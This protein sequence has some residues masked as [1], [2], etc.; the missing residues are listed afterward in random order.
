VGKNKFYLHLLRNRAEKLAQR[1][2][3]F[4][5][6]KTLTNKLLSYQLHTQDVVQAI[7][8]SNHNAGGWYLNRGA[9]QLVIRGVG[10]VHHQLALTKV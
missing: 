5:V 9:E 8:D 1:L 4:L 10:W 7:E 2:A 6:S 3:Y